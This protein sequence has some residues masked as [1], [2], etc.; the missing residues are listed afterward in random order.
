MSY[1][2]YDSNGYL[3]DF[4]TNTGLSELY[5]YA[6]KSNLPRTKGFIEM[7]A[8]L[9]TEKWEKE[10]QDAMPKDK[11]IKSTIDTLR[12]YLFKGNLVIILKDGIN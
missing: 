9:I 7:G 4:C 10:L 1:T 3:G 2:I 8:A 6:E 11:N 12:T 5:N